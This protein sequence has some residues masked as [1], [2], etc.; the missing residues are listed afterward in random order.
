MGFMTFTYYFGSSF[1]I[2]EEVWSTLCCKVIDTAPNGVHDVHL[3]FPKFCIREVQ[4]TLCCKR[5]DTTP[6]GIR[7]V[8][9]LF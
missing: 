3:L 1:S 5:I 2:G 8:R 9:L 7:G 6:D 4:S